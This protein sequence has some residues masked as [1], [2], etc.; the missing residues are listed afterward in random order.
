VLKFCR[1]A[2]RI[3]L[4]LAM[5]QHRLG[6]EADTR[7][8]FARAAKW[9]DGATLPVAGAG[10]WSWYDQVEVRCLRRETERLLRGN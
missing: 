7:E 4:F 1:L 3:L 10:S 6:Q 2:E 8:S 9:F 5:A